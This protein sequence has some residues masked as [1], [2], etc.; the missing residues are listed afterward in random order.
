M[1]CFYFDCMPFAMSYIHNNN[2]HQHLKSTFWPLN[3]KT[4]LYQGWKTSAFSATLSC[5]C[6]IYNRR[7]L[8]WEQQRQQKQQP[9]AVTPT[10]SGENFKR[11][12]NDTQINL[13]F[14]V[15]FYEKITD[16]FFLFLNFVF[17]SVSSIFDSNFSA[18]LFD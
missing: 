15:D 18:R 1:N 13:S 8:K 2:F 4:N 5:K 12:I 17:F 14:S 6:H 9:V 3:M 7:Q 10:K 16:F 11:P